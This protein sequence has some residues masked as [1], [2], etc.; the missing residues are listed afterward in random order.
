M[1]TEELL[2]TLASNSDLPRLV[3]RVDREEL[4]WVLVPDAAV[5]KWERRDPAGWAKASMW[6]AARRVAIVRI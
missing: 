2:A 4:P 1:T 5:K 3:A 6:F